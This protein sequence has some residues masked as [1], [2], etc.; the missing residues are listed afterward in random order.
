VQGG[1][2][3]GLVSAGTAR[4]G[5]ARM[6]QGGVGTTRRR[7]GRTPWEGVAGGGADGT[8]GL[9][10]AGLASRACACGGASDPT[11]RR[12]FLRERWDPG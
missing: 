8:G 11:C 10:E 5:G 9:E 6:G 12:R 3:K 2:N 1:R 4:A 7:S